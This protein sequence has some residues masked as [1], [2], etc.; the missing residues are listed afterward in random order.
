MYGV[1]EEVA[2]ELKSNVPDPF[3]ATKVWTRGRENGIAQRS[4]TLL[5]AKQIDLMQIH[6]LVDCAHASRHTARVEI[7]GAHSLH[8]HHA[9][10]DER[11]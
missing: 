5:R 10:H 6:N 2:G 11:V 8:G 3:V 7:R 1:A 9:L 4:M